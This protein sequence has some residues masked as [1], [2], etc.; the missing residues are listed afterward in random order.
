MTP[1]D[2][3]TLIEKWRAFAAV[4]D[5]CDPASWLAVRDS[6]R[7]KICADELDAILQGARHPNVVLCSCPVVTGGQIARSLSCPIHGAG[8]LQ[9]QWEMPNPRQPLTDE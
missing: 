5:A 6:T 1:T 2:V 7:L 8:R 3:K 9:E 4:L